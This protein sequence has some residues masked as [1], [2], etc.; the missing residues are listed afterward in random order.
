VKKEDAICTKRTLD[1]GPSIFIRDKPNFSSERMSHGDFYRKS[2]VG[3]E[4]WSQVLRG[5]ASRRTDWR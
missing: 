5:L 2:S 4:F 1:E 3:K